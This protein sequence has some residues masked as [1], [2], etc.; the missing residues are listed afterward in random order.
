MNDFLV[1]QQTGLV[2]MFLLLLAGL[3]LQRTTAV[4]GSSIAILDP[5]VD[6]GISI[7]LIGASVT[8]MLGFVI[9]TLR[10]IRL[11]YYARLREF[12]KM[13]ELELDREELQAG[14]YI[15]GV[16]PRAQSNT[17]VAAPYSPPIQ[18]PSSVPPPPPPPPPP[19]SN[20]DG[21]G[22]EMS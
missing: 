10:Y 6:I 4:S 7:L 11:F 12:K 16:D 8:V 15:V 1:I 13:A 17:V 14:P 9:Y 20:D 21:S 22:V 2:E 3:V 19:P 5:V 18:K